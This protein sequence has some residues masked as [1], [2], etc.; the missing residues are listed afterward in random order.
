[1]KSSNAAEFRPDYSNTDPVVGLSPDFARMHSRIGIAP[2]LGQGEMAIGAIVP[3]DRPSNAI[4]ALEDR[5]QKDVRAA[6][7]HVLHDEP[8][9]AE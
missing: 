5:L 4:E 2:S 1:M 6:V 7:A 3:A 8:D 9:T